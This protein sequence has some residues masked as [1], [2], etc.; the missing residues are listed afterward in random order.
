MPERLLSFS[1]AVRC[2][3]AAGVLGLTLTGAGAGS[4][5]ERT[6]LAF[7]AAAPEG[8]PGELIDPS[9][10]RLAG[11]RY[12]I[13]SGAREWVIEAA[14]VHVHREVA[15]PFYEVIPPRPVPLARRMLWRAALALAASRAGVAVL[16]A[17]RR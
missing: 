16:R 7:S 13:A 2:R 9:V 17:L 6:S 4:P 14:A 3:R 10:E 15:A 1:G 11:N 12:R 8:F 5:A